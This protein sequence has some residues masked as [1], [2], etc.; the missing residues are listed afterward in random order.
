MSLVLGVNLSHDRSACLILDGKVA[1]AVEEERLDRIRHSEGFLVAGYFDRLTKTL[2]MKAIT[3]C[4]RAAGVGLDD[5]DLVVG[6]RHASDQSELRLRR[7]LPIRDPGR[8]RELPVPSHHLAH[9]YACYFASPFDDAAIL[10]VDGVGGRLPHTGRIEKHTVFV[11]TGAEV[12]SVLAASYSPDF[13]DVGLG[14]FYEYFTAK[15]GFITR[16]GHPMFGSFSCGGYTEAGKTMGLAPYG[17]PR[18]DWDRLLHL[19][20]DDVSVTVAA[21]DAAWRRWYEKEGRGFDPAQ[22]GSWDTP[23]AKDVARK[24]QDELGAAMLHLAHRAH[25]LTGKRRLCLTGGVALNSVANQRIV[26]EGPFDE[27]YILPPAGDAGVALGAGYYGYYRLLGGRQRHH[28]RS[29][30]V[31]RAY[32]QEEV[33]SAI[34]NAGA[35]IDYRETSPEEVADLLAGHHVV[36]WFDG[37]SEIGPQA[38]GK[39]SILADPRHPA[40]RDYLNVVVKHREPFRPYPPSVLAEHAGDWFDL[41]GGSPFTLLAPEVRQDRRP[42][43]PAITHVDG[44]ARVQTVDRAVNPRYHQLIEAFAERTRVP[45]VLNTSFND[46]GE[47]IVETPDDALRT[48]LRTEL[49]YLFLDGYLIS[50]PDRSPPATHPRHA[51]LSAASGREDA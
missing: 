47:P 12:R 16:W 46:P 15:L 1:V 40:M 6:N 26:S 9:A 25:Q 21:L 11:G 33:L 34:K 24:V 50:K 48:F 39:R 19:D 7:E 30:G 29:A 4:L 49:D 28:L 27:V 44:T 38:L 10:V 23:F 45:L 31:G 13:T 22:P 36:G 37:G 14:L 18:G 32:Q 17:N 2:P 5:L 3:Y 43:V 42:V 8:I 35:D 51:P 41:S 20:G